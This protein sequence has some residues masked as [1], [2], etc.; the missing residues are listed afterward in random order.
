MTNKILHG[1]LLFRTRLW[2]L[3]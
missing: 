2:L 3:H 1:E